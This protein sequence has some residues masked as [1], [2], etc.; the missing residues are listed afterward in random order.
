MNPE[1]HRPSPLRAAEFA[2]QQIRRV[3]R[4]LV[5]VAASITCSCVDI[6]ANIDLVS[7]SDG[8]LG[9]P[10]AVNVAFLPIAIERER[11]IDAERCWGQRHLQGPDSVPHK[12]PFSRE[13][14]ARGAT[15]RRSPLAHSITAE[16]CAR[17]LTLVINAVTTA[18]RKGRI[19]AEYK[20]ATFPGTASRAP[21]A[22]VRGTFNL[23]LNSRP[24]PGAGFAQSSET[25]S[26]FRTPHPV[27]PAVR[28]RRNKSALI[29]AAVRWASRALHCPSV[30]GYVSGKRDA[31]GAAGPALTRGGRS[32][33]PPLTEASQPSFQ[34]HNPHALHTAHALGPRLPTRLFSTVQCS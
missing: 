9:C 34:R 2:V 33:V 8:G 5:P 32:A 18:R 17:I 24:P 19:D 4:G 16:L 7:R 25:K 28:Q 26:E 10:N 1:S 30:N 3:R 12:L 29:G 20:A 31:Y 22:A 23:H 13:A 27:K 14:S 21:S 6:C 11:S 15:P